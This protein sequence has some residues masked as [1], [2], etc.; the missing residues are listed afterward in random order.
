M[1]INFSF[2]HKPFC[3]LC[4]FFILSCGR[5][6]IYD[7]E[8]QG[9]WGQDASYVAATVAD[10]LELVT[11]AISENSA[12][13]QPNTGTN[14][15][16]I[17][18]APEVGTGIPQGN[19]ASFPTFPVGQLTCS[20]IN[21]SATV[22][23]AYGKALDFS[24]PG[25][26]KQASATY[27]DK[28]SSS[29]N[30]TRVWGRPQAG[31]SY[32]CESDGRLSLGS[33]A[34]AKED[35]VKGLKQTL[36]YNSKIIKFD[37]LVQKGSLNN[38]FGTLESTSTGT[39]VSNWDIPFPKADALNFF[40]TKTS[41]INVT[42]NIKLSGSRGNFLLN[43]TAKTKPESLLRTEIRRLN[44]TGTISFLYLQS[45]TLS[46]YDLSKRQT[47][48]MSFNSLKFDFSELNQNRC[49]PV[50]GTLSGRVVPD[51]QLSSESFFIKFQDSLTESGIS[52]DM[53]KTGAKD[54]ESCVFRWCDFFQ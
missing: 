49:I 48:E 31:D 29:G 43:L 20:T 41:D 35:N 2:L 32:T 19:L 47:L 38:E 16:N 7:T 26:G 22:T 3:A 51:G 53:N 44:T 30:E 17:N 15:G 14:L 8:G 45:G 28:I 36:T 54:C 50:D 39:V 37:S 24:R 52:L 40:N 34:W 46:L 13:V 23:L 11:S 27:K 33:S 10:A 1:K 21:D 5:R 6:D 4:F 25:R 42:R 12:S 9:S 18:I